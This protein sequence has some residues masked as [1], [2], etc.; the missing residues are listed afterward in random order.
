MKEVKK[1]AKK[2]DSGLNRRNAGHIDCLLSRLAVSIKKFFFRTKTGGNSC[3]VEQMKNNTKNKNM[4][5][6]ASGR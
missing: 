3:H 2:F 6:C 1:V 4:V 5:E